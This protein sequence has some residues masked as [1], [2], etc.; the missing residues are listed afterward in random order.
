MDYPDFQGEWKEKAQLNVREI[1]RCGWKSPLE[2]DR[3]GLIRKVKLLWC[4]GGA[5]CRSLETEVPV[6]SLLSLIVFS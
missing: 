1:R 2:F 3:R 4:N 6:L 5:M